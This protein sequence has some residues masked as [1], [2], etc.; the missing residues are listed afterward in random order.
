V[1]ASRCGLLRQRGGK[2]SLDEAAPLLLQVLDGL[3]NAHNAE[4]P[5]VPHTE[6]DWSPGCGLVHRDV[7]P[8]NI[9]LGASGSSPMAKIGDF[10]LAKA[11]DKAGLS[12]HTWSG[13]LSGTPFF[14]PRQQV[15]SYKYSRPEVDVWA[16]AATFYY[17]LT[18]VPARDF[19]RGNGW[20]EVVL[21]SPAVP[22]RRRLPSLP[23]RLA[24]LLDAAL[25]DRPEI[26]FKTAAGFKRALLAAL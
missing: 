19:S 20:M 26:P 16:L 11:F 6:G 17:V 8:A 5:F 15:L 3:E 4:V 7:K 2:L 14:M 23:G 9:F 25:V 13:L 22:I 18:G 12:G 1:L 21:E 10:G 24:E